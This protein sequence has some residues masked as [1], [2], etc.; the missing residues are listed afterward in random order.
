[1]DRGLTSHGGDLDGGGGGRVIDSFPWGFFCGGVG[2]GRFCEFGLGYFL[3]LRAFFSK[4]DEIL[5][6][7]NMNNIEFH[8]IDMEL[9]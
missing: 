7:I 3:Y 2:G 4:V 9:K 5:I 1:M 6:I 8:N